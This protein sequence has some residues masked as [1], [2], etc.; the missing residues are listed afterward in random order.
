MLVDRLMSRTVAIARP[1][2]S[3][4]LAAGRMKESNLG[5]LPVCGPDNS[6]EV[7]GVLTDRDI[8]MHAC[9]RERPLGELQVEHAMTRSVK[10][11]RENDTLT[12]AQQIMAEA[13]VRRLPVV[14]GSGHLIGIISLA[15]IAAEADRLSHLE[16]QAVTA[17]EVAATFAA[18]AASQRPRATRPG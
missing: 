4:Q 16:K 9:E 1:E 12:V 11:C 14:D 3:L 15:D 5:V 7:V 8:C 18:I 2:E 17:A 13:G 10:Y 6:D